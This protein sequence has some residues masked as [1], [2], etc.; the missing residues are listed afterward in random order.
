MDQSI[1]GEIWGSGG[2]LFKYAMW[3]FFSVGISVGFGTVGTSVG[4]SLGESVR[5][6]A[7]VFARN[8]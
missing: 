7:Q 6:H 3:E 8:F 4:E 1:F 2:E 5:E